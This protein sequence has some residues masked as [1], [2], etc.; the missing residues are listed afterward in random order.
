MTARGSRETSS[1]KAE[2]ILRETVLSF[3]DVTDRK[4][5]MQADIARTVRALLD[6]AG[7]RAE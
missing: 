5:L 1:T 3:R 2:D 6:S 7:R 4:P